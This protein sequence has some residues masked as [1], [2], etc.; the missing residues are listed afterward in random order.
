MS[1]FVLLAYSS[2]I[3]KETKGGEGDTALN[4]QRSDWP[5]V[6]DGAEKKRKVKT[7]AIIVIFPFG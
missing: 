5:A 2:L 4:K 1:I 6:I 7:R 3:N